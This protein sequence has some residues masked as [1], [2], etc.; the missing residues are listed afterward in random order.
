MTL[1]DRIKIAFS[2]KKNIASNADQQGDYDTLTPRIITDNSVKPYFDAL[3]FAFSKSDVKNIAIT[4]PYG[5]GKSTIILSYL[6]IRLKHNFIN[7]SLADFSLSGK[8]NSNPLENSDIELSI[9]QQI[10]YTEKKDNLPDSRIDRIKNRDKKHIFS[11]FSSILTLAIPLFLLL[12]SLFPKKILSFFSYDEATINTII[13]ILPERLTT[14]VAVGIILLFSIVRIASKIGIFDKKIKL[15]KIAF[16]QGSADIS[17][18]EPPSLLNNSL[19]EMVYFFTRSKYKIVVFEDLDR[20]SS[21]EVFVKLRE[22]NQIVNNNLKNE[23]VRFIYACRDDI[24]LGADIRTKFFDFILPVIPVMDTRNAYTHLKNKLNGFPVNGQ[25]LLKQMSLYINDMRSLQNI[26]NEFNLFKKVVDNNKNQEK[27]FALIFYKN[28]HAQDYNL[29]DKKFGVLY[30]LIQDYRLKKLH[31]NYFNSL[32]EKLEQ[33]TIQLEKI[34]NESATSSKELRKE[35]IS[36]FIPP[37]LWSLV[38]FSERNS[39]WNGST[40]VNPEN[41]YNDENEFITLFS[42]DIPLYIGCGNSNYNAGYIPIETKTVIEEYN[43]RILIIGEDKLKEFKITTENINKTKEKIR[44]RNSISLE[45][46]LK[47][48]GFDQFKVICETYINKCS[49][50]SII[51]SEQ[52]ETIRNGYRFGGFEALYYLLIN[53]YIMQDFMTFR[54]IFHQGTISVNDND[55]IKAVGRYMDCEEVNRNFSLDNP[56]DI[57]DELVSQNYQ[58]RTGAIH[59]QIMSLLLNSKNKNHHSTL[60]SIIDMIFNEFHTKT[61]SIFNILKDKFSDTNDFVQL[62]IFSLGKNHY[63]DKMITIL[64]NQ[65]SNNI[66]RLITQIMISSISPDLSSDK[67][68]YRSFIEGQ[69]F[70]LISHVENANLDNFLKNINN[71]GVIY[72]D[73]HPPVT[74]NEKH[75]LSFLTEHKMYPI[76]KNSFPIIVCGLLNNTELTHDKVNE[77]PWTL[78]CKHQLSSIKEYIENNIDVFVTEIF[79]NSKENNDAIISIL[80]HPKLSDELKVSIIKNMK[81]TV[82]NLDEFPRNI[83]VEDNEYSYYDL[84]YLYEHV[85]PEWKTLLDYIN[86]EHHPDVLNLYL[87]NNAQS[88]S[89]KEISVHEGELYE[90]IYINIICNNRLSD[91]AYNAIVKPINININYWNERLSLI[92]FSRLIESN[93]VE[94]NKST[95]DFAIKHY[96]NDIN[97]ENFGPLPLWFSKFKNHFIDNKDDYILNEQNGNNLEGILTSIYNSDYFTLSEKAFLL[98]SYYNYYQPTFL[99]ELN[100]PNDILLALIEQSHDDSFTILIIIRLLKNSYCKKENIKTLIDKLKEK[101]F[102]KIFRHKTTTLNINNKKDAELLLPALEKASLIKKWS[103]KE[104]GKYYVYCCYE[105]DENLLD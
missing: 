87:E 23:P 41:I 65:E 84:F 33:L 50:I 13:N 21:T 45:D 104:A 47:S 4:G 17:P 102:R 25:T 29:I 55:Y 7:V 5:A 39:Y 10:L 44:I 16:T 35:I 67:E 30:N 57:L 52:L 66:T 9:L 6:K 93:K 43:E 62:V 1:L 82:D 12:I 2:R 51:D 64:E 49:D 103:L 38:H 76:D 40:I 83:E 61:L 48:I 96:I 74:Q 60:S 88:L 68:K 58:Y 69:G 32:D 75:A 18:Q 100:L 20:L 22:I 36:Q 28:I 59:H 92:N 56:K 71:L 72:H 91:S 54:S 34:N 19:D 63:L 90:L 77:L 14:S 105:D 98:H 86:E 79:M 11:L 94:L 53:G 95:F 89:E 15:N 80:I 26:V 101:E 85:I 81:F 78:V 37:H 8:S 73:I 31:E 24:F 42:K 70:G 27:I 3:D 46:L 97:K 99:D